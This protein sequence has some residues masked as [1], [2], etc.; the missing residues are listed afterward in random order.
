MFRLRTSNHKLPIETGRY[1][2][3]ELKD[4]ICQL[5]HKDIGD[6][7]HYLLVC[8]IFKK[9]RKKYI[10]RSIGKHP[11]MLIFIEL[12]TSKTLQVLNGLAIFSGIIMKR[13]V[14]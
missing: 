5:C 14:T 13:V 10:Q 8:Q 1:H 2:Q 9:E 7:F 6:E 4:R 3:I 12:M 11:N